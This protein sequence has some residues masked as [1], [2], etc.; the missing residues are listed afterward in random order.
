MRHHIAHWAIALFAL[1]G[2]PALAAV[3][4]NTAPQED[5]VAIKGVGPSTSAR[6]VEAREA[7]PFADWQDFIQRVRGIGPLTAR[8]LSEQGLTVNGRRFEATPSA[9]EWKPFVPTPLQASGAR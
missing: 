1:L 9:I 2:L 7:R 8:K 5:L 3:D 4:V 6:I